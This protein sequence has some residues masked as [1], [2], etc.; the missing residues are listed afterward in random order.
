MI[1]KDKLIKKLSDSQIAFQLHE[2]EP[3]FTV[4]DSEK[5]RGIIGGVHTKNLFFKNKKM[6]IFYFPAKKNNL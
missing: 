3:F 6:N 2:H 5:K 1:T 4:N